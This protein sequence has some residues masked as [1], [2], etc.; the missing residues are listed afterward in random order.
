[1]AVF[2]SLCVYTLTVDVNTSSLDDV[3]DVSVG[4][5][6]QVNSETELRSVINN[7]ASNTPTIIALDNNIYLAK[8][9]LV[10]GANQEITL[11][12][13][14][15]TMEY[16]KLVGAE[17]VSTI[18]VG[19][20]GTLKLDGIIVT[21][22]KSGGRLGGGGCMLKKMGDLF[23][24]VVKS[25]VILLIGTVREGVCIIQV[26]LKCTMAKSPKTMH[27]IFA[28]L[29]VVW[30]VVCVTMVLLQCMAARLP[31]IRIAKWWCVQ[32]GHV[33]HVWWQNNK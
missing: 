28:I 2:A 19:G 30:V 9:S 11:T 14:H 23:C 29:M 6:V 27:K 24:I 32:L 22:T 8:G 3:G 33:Y 12:S 25:L 15:K 21:H 31:T 16:C 1:M 10:I 20:N 17:G 26:F 13:G 5:V 7:T 4:K 18:F